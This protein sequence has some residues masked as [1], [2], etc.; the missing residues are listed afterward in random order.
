MPRTQG[1]LANAIQRLRLRPRA[2]A[3]PSALACS[4]M[5]DSG[6]RSS[7]ATSLASRRSRAM[8]A[9]WR[10]SKVLMEASTDSNSFQAF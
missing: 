10:S 4:A 3:R 6:V 2:P 8:A 7:C 5:D 1:V 9:C